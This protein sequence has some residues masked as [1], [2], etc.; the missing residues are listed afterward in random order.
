MSTPSRSLKKRSLPNSNRTSPVIPDQWIL[1]SGAT[2]HMSGAR[3][4]F[5]HIDNS[6]TGTIRFGDGSVIEIEGHG[7]V[8]FALKTGE[9]RE[10]EDVYFIPNLKANIISLGQLVEAGC[11]I[12]LDADQLTIHDEQQHLLARVKQ[13]PTRLYFLSLT[14]L[15]QFASLP[16]APNKPGGGM[17]DL[18]M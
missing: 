11:R 6:V 1:N 10:L 4:A 12:V 5:A 14:S 15:A 9:H 13:T 16:R 7:V 3:S 18:A 8:S 17:S 2:N